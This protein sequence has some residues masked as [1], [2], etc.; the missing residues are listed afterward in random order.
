VTVYLINRRR[1]V[2]NKEVAIKAVVKLL[3]YS[4]AKEN[5]QVIQFADGVVDVVIGEMFGY[6]A[7]NAEEC[8][9]CNFCI[10]DW[11]WDE[12]M[13]VLSDN[14]LSVEIEDLWLT[15]PKPEKPGGASK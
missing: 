13:C 14:K 7:K 8:Y 2:M 1:K 10:P 3:G 9:K 4:M 15:C 11:D 6:K 5:E 12:D